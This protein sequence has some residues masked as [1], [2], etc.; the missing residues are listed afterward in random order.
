MENSAMERERETNVSFPDFAIKF[1]TVNYTAIF[2][3]F[4]GR[5]AV[6]KCLINNLLLLLVNGYVNLRANR[7][8]FD[9]FIPNETRIFEWPLLK[10]ENHSSRVLLAFSRYLQTPSAVSSPE[11]SF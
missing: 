5:I 11:F 10:R 6:G 8:V 3:D 7:F 2:S 4:K 9:I 1:L